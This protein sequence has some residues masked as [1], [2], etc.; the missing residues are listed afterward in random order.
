M[1]GCHSHSSDL[2]VLLGYLYLWKQQ[3]VAHHQHH[4][5]RQNGRKDEH[6]QQQIYMGLST[7]GRVKEGEAKRGVTKDC[8]NGVFMFVMNTKIGNAITDIVTYPTD[9]LDG[10]IGRDEG[11]NEERI[12]CLRPARVLECMPD[13]T[14]YQEMIKER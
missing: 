13:T 5:L 6:F 2:E 3:G 10:F 12:D 8:F 7:Q 1:I 4:N 11:A 14:R 9:F